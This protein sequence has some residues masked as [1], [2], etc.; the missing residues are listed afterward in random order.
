MYPPLGDLLTTIYSL[1]FPIDPNKPITDEQKTHFSNLQRSLQRI[2]DPDKSTKL[3]IDE[4]IEASFSNIEHIFSEQRTK[5]LI[6]AN[7]RSFL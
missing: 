6:F 4:I 5:M 7:L 2:E 1:C 3:T